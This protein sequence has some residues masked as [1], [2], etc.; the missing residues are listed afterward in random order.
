MRYL[1]TAVLAATLSLVLGGCAT[2]PQVKPRAVNATALTSCESDQ[3]IPPSLKG[4]ARTGDSAQPV[5]VV[6]CSLH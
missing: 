1:L 6:G 5:L 2:K 3:V 4:A